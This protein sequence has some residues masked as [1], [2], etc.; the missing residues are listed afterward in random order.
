MTDL[1]SSNKVKL[2]VLTSVL[3][4]HVYPHICIHLYTDHIYVYTHYLRVI[5][6]TTNT[7]ATC[8]GNDLFSIA[9]FITERSQELKEGRDMEAGADADH[10]GVMITGF[11]RLF[12]YRTKYHQMGWAL[13]HQSII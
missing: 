9:L 4:I 7:K 6:T 5:I 3:H 10:G 2:W 13:P 8:G 11:L 12:S 1:V